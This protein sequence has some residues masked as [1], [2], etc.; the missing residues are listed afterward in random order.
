MPSLCAREE[1]FGCL[2]PCIS[3]L[4]L[5]SYHAI[6]HHKGVSQSTV[7]FEDGATVSC[8]LLL[9]MRSVVIHYRI[10]SILSSCSCSL[11]GVTQL[12][13]S[14]AAV[15]IHT[16]RLPVIWFCSSECIPPGKVRD[17]ICVGG[18]LLLVMFSFPLPDSYILS[19]LNE[20]LV[21]W[22]PSQ[23]V[24][25]H[26]GFARLFT[27]SREPSNRAVRAV[28]INLESACYWPVYG[29]M[30]VV[31]RAPYWQLFLAEL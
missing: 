1:L 23:Q 19:S 18:L 26:L 8:F 9:G 17:Y 27:V 16:S 5:A 31:L 20:C 10:G 25:F 4:P 21:L 6:F 29:V 13:L 3:L 30:M 2:G 7:T 11:F 14:A 24:A 22:G 28:S 12:Q 15:I